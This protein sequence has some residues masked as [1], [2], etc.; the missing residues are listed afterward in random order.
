MAG[1]NAYKNE[2]WQECIDELNLSLNDL[3]EEEERCRMMCDDDLD[4][5]SLQGDNPEYSIVIS[6]KNR[7]LFN[8]PIF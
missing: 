5:S 3:F 1:V 4:W 2:D 6:S 8:R 7:E